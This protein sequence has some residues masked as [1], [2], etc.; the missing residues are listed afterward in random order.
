MMPCT[1][2]P[3]NYKLHQVHGIPFFSFFLLKQSPVK[4]PAK[5]IKKTATPK[6]AA[7]PKPTPKSAAKAKPAAAPKSVAEPKPTP[8]AKAK[9]E[10]E[11]KPVPMEEDA[12]PQLPSEEP[13][14]KARASLSFFPLVMPQ[15]NMPFTLLYIYGTRHCSIMQSTG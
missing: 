10:Q 7:K 8:K 5:S 12:A 6:S 11:L 13:V 14:L 4:S 1:Q 15:P 9:A 2:T 3:V